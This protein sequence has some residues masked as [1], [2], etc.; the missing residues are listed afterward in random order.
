MTRLRPPGITASRWALELRRLGTTPRQWGKARV[1][2]GA[3]RR[4]W[5]FRRQPLARRP[6]QW[7]TTRVC[8]RVA[9]AEVPHC[10]CASPKPSSAVSQVGLGSALARLWRTHPGLRRGRHRLREVLNLDGRGLHSNGAHDR[11]HELLRNGAW[12]LHYRLG[13]L[14]HR[15]GSWGAGRR[16]NPSRLADSVDLIRY[17]TPRARRAR[18]PPPRVFTPPRWAK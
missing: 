4:P 1:R 3:G 16:S 8:C 2:S 6:R 7:A 15:H 14:L 13:R 18:R 11:C 5:V 10:A 17:L 12:R 9:R